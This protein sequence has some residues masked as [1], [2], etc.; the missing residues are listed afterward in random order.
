M[1][2]CMVHALVNTQCKCAMGNKK[3]YSSVQPAGFRDSKSNCNFVFFRD[4][5]TLLPKHQPLTA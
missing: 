2:A 1:G 4:R 3:Y 5:G